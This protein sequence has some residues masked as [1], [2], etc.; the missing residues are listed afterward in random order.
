MLDKYKVGQPIAYNILKNAILNDKLSHAYLFDSNNNS[1]SFDIVMS[2]VKEIVCNDENVNSDVICKRIDDGNY[3]DVKV[4][5]TD[6]IW[7]K[8]DQLI[9]LQSEFSKKPIEGKRKIYIIKSAEKMNLQSSNSILKFLE[10]PVDNIIAILIVN[11]INLLLP[12]IISRCQ[13]IKLNRNSFFDSYLEN[14][15]NLIKDSKYDVYSDNDKNIF[16][17]NVI[18]FILKFEENK[19]D[20]LIY[21]KK[22]WHNNFDDRDICILAADVMIYFYYDVIKYKSKLNIDF[23]VD[24]LD[25]IIKVA[26]LNDIESIT[27]KLLCLDDFRT[28]IK[29]NLNINLLVDRLIIDMCGDYSEYCWC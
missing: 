14:F 2:F 29:R 10:E 22:L 24:K 19:I 8:K 23:F 28:N 27:E 25:I 9:S 21:T 26:N 13:V 3:L 6:G 16:I 11:N 5:D 4:I 15:S 12:T 20:T 18:N 1:D 17:N 7:I